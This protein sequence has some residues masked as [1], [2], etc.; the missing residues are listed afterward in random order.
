M[1]YGIKLQWEAQRLIAF[2][3]TGASYVQ[4]GDAFTHPIRQLIISNLTDAS[5]QFAIG[6]AGLQA[7]DVV[8]SFP[9][10]AYTQFIN[11]VSSNRVQNN[12][13]FAAQGDAVYVKRIGTPTVGTVYV[14]ASYAKGD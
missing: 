14:S 2:G 4:I 12:P 8:D 7:A 3:S 10:L 11:D 13:L 6:P 9:L 1:S 5:M